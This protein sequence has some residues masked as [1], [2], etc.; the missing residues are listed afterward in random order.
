MQAQDRA[1]SEDCLTLNVW[2]PLERPEKP[3]PVTVWI[4]GG[5][6]RAGASALPGT[7]LVPQGVILVAIQYRLGDFAV[8]A[9]PALSRA[10]KTEPL[11]NYGL[12]DQIAR[13]AVRD[14]FILAA[15]AGHVRRPVI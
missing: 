8:F 10:Q 1:M 11:A 14:R 13:Q 12:M 4:H 9:H 3:L 5:G 2:T 7:G 15:D 6:F